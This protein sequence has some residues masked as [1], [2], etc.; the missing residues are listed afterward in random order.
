MNTLISLMLFGT[1]FGA[2]A[3][4][5]SDSTKAAHS[6]TKSFQGQFWNER[7]EQK[8]TKLFEQNGTASYYANSL[9]GRRTASG[10]TYYKDSLVC[11]HKTIKLGTVL[12]VTNLSNDSVVFVTVIDR[13]GRNT[14]HI[15]DL[16][17]A[18]AKQLNFWGKGIAKV[19]VEEFMLPVQVADTVKKTM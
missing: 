5:N 3:V 17:M 9:N 2:F 10:K 15:I 1:L 13:M 4:K 16:S 6:A 14:P 18:G 12:K 11:A 8:N 7:L 19:R